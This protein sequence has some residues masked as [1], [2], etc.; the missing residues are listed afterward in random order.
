MGSI[1]IMLSPKC[2]QIDDID[3]KILEE[4]TKNSKISTREL[5]KIIGLS[6]PA[7]SARIAKLEKS[8]VIN[9]YTIEINP[10]NLGY[11]VLIEFGYNTTHE[12][13]EE[14]IEKLRNCKEILSICLVT[15]DHTITGRGAFRNLKE[16][17]EFMEKKIFPL[18]LDKSDT[19]IVLK[20][21]QSSK[22][23][24]RFSLF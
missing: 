17:Q 10:E 2:R 11:E 13:I 4:L 14:I 22:V 12:K 18:G 23:K 19:S 15:G 8:K 16:F 6:P 24:Y 21:Y 20:R 7:V 3:M 1:K 5:S 9:R